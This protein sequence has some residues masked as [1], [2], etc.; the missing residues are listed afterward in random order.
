MAN[1]VTVTLRLRMEFDT[2]SMQW[3]GELT[4]KAREQGEV[5]LLRVDDLPVSLVL[6]GTDETAAAHVRAAQRDGGS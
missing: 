6:E 2:D 3:L 1:F 4:D 5:E